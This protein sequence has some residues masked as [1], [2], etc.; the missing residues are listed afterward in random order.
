MT[1]LLVS[2]FCL[3]SIITFSTSAMG[4][5]A[6]ASSGRNGGKDASAA[7][8]NTWR[9]S[10]PDEDDVITFKSGI[11][12]HDGTFVAQK[13]LGP[14][15]K[16]TFPAGGGVAPKF[17]P[18]FDRTTVG[19]CGSE[20]TSKNGA[21]AATSTGEY[22]GTNYF[23][24]WGCSA[25]GI[26]GTVQPCANGPY[27]E[28]ETTVED[29]WMITPETLD[30]LE[31]TE[32]NYDLYV[33]VGLDSAEYSAH[34]LV[35]LTASYETVSGS[36]TLL[37]IELSSGTPIVTNDGPAGLYFYRLTDPYEGPTENPDSLKTLAD[38]QS[39]LAADV[40]GD[41]FLDHPMY[42]GIVWQDIPVPTVDMDDSTDAV[43]KI[44]VNMRTMDRSTTLTPV[45]PRTPAMAVL[46][47]AL[48]NPFNRSTTFRF[49]LAERA[50]VSF[51]I[52]DAAGRRVRTLLD[53]IRMDGSRSA[54]WDG[55]DDR[56]LPVA[57]GIYFGS[58]RA[59][60]Q[61]LTTKAVLLK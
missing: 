10:T 19:Q 61:Q 35:E 26:L 5:T 33:P 12:R 40:S 43:A 44:H 49:E 27:W 25:F 58:L 13:T 3:L 4:A 7:G 34:G 23:C 17:N 37:R 38:I 50:N 32:S 47:D 51:A 48:P 52:Y 9:Y 2:V 8:H 30:S 18:G 24:A 46:H 16:F 29:P 54:E 56:G 57:S 42:L 14:Y 11:N 55:R 59:G 15:E 28:A 53:N 21:N 39:D 22:W 31:V 1:R 20:A 6:K 45:M 41:R 36:V 60:S